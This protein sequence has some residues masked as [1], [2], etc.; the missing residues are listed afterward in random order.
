MAV[1]AAAAATTM[2][3]ACGSPGTGWLAADTTFVR[4]SGTV[5]PPPTTVDSTDP[6]L[7][8]LVGTEWEVVTLDGTSVADRLGPVSLRFFGDGTYGFQGGCPGGGYQITGRHIDFDPATGGPGPAWVEDPPELT[9]LMQG[10]VCSIVDHGMNVSAF[11]KEEIHAATVFPNA[12]A[13]L[14]RPVATPSP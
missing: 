3:V 12:F 13:L 14:L 10:R 7:R 5:A 11:S 6:L 1:V 9:V 4:P 2:L 8:T